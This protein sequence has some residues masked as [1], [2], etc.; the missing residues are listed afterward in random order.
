MYIREYQLK[1]SKLYHFHKVDIKIVFFPTS[2][3]NNLLYIKMLL[4]HSGNELYSEQ[5]G[6]G[7]YAVYYTSPQS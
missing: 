4:N 5:G 7:H 1:V 6:R 2:S 3:K